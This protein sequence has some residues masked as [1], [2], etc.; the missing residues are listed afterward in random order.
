VIASVG[1]SADALADHRGQTGQRLDELH[2]TITTLLLAHGRLMFA[3]HDAAGYFAECLR[4]LGRTST[5][6]FKYWELLLQHGRVGYADDSPEPIERLTELTELMD[7]WEPIVDTAIM[8]PE[9]AS[10]MGCPEDFAC[11]RPPD[12]GPELVA[13]DCVTA[14]DTLRGLQALDGRRHIRK[15]SLR[16]TFWRQRCAPLVR[17][18]DHVHLQDRYLVKH[19]LDKR[20]M[21][22]LKQAELGWLLSCVARDG[23][24]VTVSIYSASPHAVDSPVICA[25][26][27]ELASSLRLARVGGIERLQLFLLP[28]RDWREARGEAHDR[29]LR[30]EGS[31]VEVSAGF[32]RLRAEKLQVGFTA[33]Y[34]YGG[35]TQKLKDEESEVR[36][37]LGHKPYVIF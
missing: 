13:H 32:D 25:R 18:A 20:S 12:R 26:L 1:V 35:E 30:V 9:R 14:S 7:Q 23:R 28:D 11:W 36:K 4:E 29:H 33:T 6:A 3:D 21:H 37:R 2:R 27:K 5:L 31:G 15:G 16:D 24:G 10:I 19:L 22:A 34:F 8:E 17:D